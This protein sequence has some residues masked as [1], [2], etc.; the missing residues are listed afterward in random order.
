M[1]A[2]ETA[3]QKARREREEKRKA[4]AGSRTSPSGTSPTAGGLRRA[5]STTS[6]N[7]LTGTRTGIGSALRTASAGTKKSHPHKADLGVGL[8][9]AVVG[10]TQPAKLLV[11][12]GT[13][14][15]TVEYANKGG[16]ATVQERSMKQMIGTQ[17]RTVD[18][19][20]AEE[21]KGGGGAVAKTTSGTF[22]DDG[23]DWAN[24]TP[25]EYTAWTKE[26]STGSRAAGKTSSMSLDL[27]PA[28]SSTTDRDRDRDRDRRRR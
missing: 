18:K 16:E 6:T 28:S 13:R 15:W 20:K 8:W 4:L 12:K 11:D 21:A 7:T 19:I 3:L 26:G 1:P 2:N 25:D 24:A 17:K 22:E 5:A 10:K 23:R 27:E 14:G 9:I